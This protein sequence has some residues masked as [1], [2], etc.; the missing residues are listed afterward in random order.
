MQHESGVLAWP[1]PSRVMAAGWRRQ[2]RRDACTSPSAA[3]GAST[4]H[5]PA[6]INLVGAMVSLLTWQGGVHIVKAED[7]PKL[8][9]KMLWQTLVTKQVWEEG[10]AAL[11]GLLVATGT[12]WVGA[13]R[14]W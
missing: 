14:R 5:L 13:D 6:A 8:A 10:G 4:L 9:E 2:W 11:C 7:A 3:G 12:D 1:C